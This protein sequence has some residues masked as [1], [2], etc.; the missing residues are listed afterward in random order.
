M[1]DQKKS[2]IPFNFAPAGTV[3][4][5]FTDIE[6]STQLLSRLRKRYSTLLSELRRI[7]RKILVKWHGHEIGTEGDSFYA[8]F[9][10]AKDAVSAAVE[11]QLELA[12]KKWPDDVSVL[13]RIGIHTGEPWVDKEGYTGLDVHRTAR[14]TNIGHGGQV[15]LSETTS[16]LV[17]DELP[18]G[19]SLLVLG[20]HHLKDMESPENIRQL[21]IQGLHSEF[22]PINSL[23]TISKEGE[24]ADDLD[25][26]YQTLEAAGI[27][28]VKY[29]LNDILRITTFGGLTIHLGTKPVTMFSSRKAEALLVYLVFNQQPFQH[30]VLAEM[31]WEGRSQSSAMSNLKVALNTLTNMLGDY[32]IINQDTL[33]INLEAPIWLDATVFQKFVNDRQF[34][35]AL[36]LYHGAFLEGFNIRS[37]HVFEDW[38]V[39]QRGRLKNLAQVA[40]DNR[41]ESN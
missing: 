4:F 21:V 10:R 2:D 37:A 36:K 3:T 27:P 32:L 28:E 39:K 12:E 22:P 34:E 38:V 26:L 7:L 11:I 14:I 33:E 6:G 41:T 18:P 1:S 17:R 20:L 15:L 19:V 9:P 23:D 5:L 35:S 29:D 25:F 30:Q 8:V 16:A 31:L 13:L 24:A 40:M